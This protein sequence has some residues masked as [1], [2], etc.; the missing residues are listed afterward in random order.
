[1][2]QIILV[3]RLG[4]RPELI[5]MESGQAL[6]SFSIATNER[7]TDKSGEKKEMT[8]WHRIKVW[9]NA[10][11][12]CSKHLKKGSHVLVNGKI[13]TRSYEDKQGGTRHVTEILANEVKFLDGAE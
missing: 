5:P 13:R 2:N 1:M 12:A 10:A 8:E 6:C 7:W 11:A 3:G 9:G 4:D